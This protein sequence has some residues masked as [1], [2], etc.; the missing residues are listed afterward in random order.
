MHSFQNNFENIMLEE[1]ILVKNRNETEIVS[2]IENIGDS[3]ND[4]TNNYICT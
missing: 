4:N 2:E 3:R 1:D